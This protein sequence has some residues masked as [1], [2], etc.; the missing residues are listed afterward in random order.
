M[1]LDFLKQLFGGSQTQQQSTS[2]P[3]DMTPDAFKS[4]QSPL[5][6]MLLNYSQ[7]QPQ[8]SGPTV[9]PIT[10]PEQNILSGMQADPSAGMR[11]NYMSD[12]MSG[13]YLPG[14]GGN[15]F[16]DEA[17][18]AAQRPTLEGLT[19]TLGRVLPGRFT[20]AGQFTQP[21]GSSAFDR[22]GAIAT[23]GAASALGD[24]A[25]NMSFGNYEAERGRQQQTV[26]LSQQEVDNTIKNLQAQGLPRMIQDLGIERGMAM[27][28]ANTQALLEAL[29][30]IA[31]VASPT[32]ANQSQS[33]GSAEQTGGAAAAF[34]NVFGGNGTPMP[35]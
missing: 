30:L 7:N 5:S 25:T 18:R 31:G 8:Y 19:E 29:K 6:S 34:K 21:Q 24:I 9:A 4:L 22:A 10:A 1:A 33:T 20:Q 2:T 12:V 17:I 35:K 13:K 26:Q 14:A 23:R 15:P 11:T 3:I 28:Q 16:L 32:I 27:F